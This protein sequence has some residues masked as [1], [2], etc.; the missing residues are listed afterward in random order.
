MTL[1]DII[2]KY[3]DKGN[4]LTTANYD[5]HR[6]GKIAACREIADDLEA[7]YSELKAETQ[8][9]LRFIEGHVKSTK[10]CWYLIDD[11]NVPVRGHDGYFVAY[12]KDEAERIAESL[13]M[14]AKFIED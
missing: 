11:N 8:Q 12:G 7:N 9:P 5:P 3:R 13:G 14:I 2:K 1:D 4:S 6:D 10:N